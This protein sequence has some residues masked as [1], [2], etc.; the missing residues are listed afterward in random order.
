MFIDNNKK[1]NWALRNKEKSNIII[2]LYNSPTFPMNLN[3]QL[4]NNI[5]I[6]IMTILKILMVKNIFSIIFKKTDIV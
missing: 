2:K 5:S 6:N 1:E 4:M 3:I